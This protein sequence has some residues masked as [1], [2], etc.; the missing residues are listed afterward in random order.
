LN[1]SI[2]TSLKLNV[3]ANFAGNFASAII[4]FIFIPIYVKYIGAE[5]YGLIGFYTAL[6]GFIQIMDFGMSGT[7]NRAISK[8]RINENEK[9]LSLN[10]FR[11]FDVI[12]TIVAILIAISF[13]F[14]SEYFAENWFN[15]TSLHKREIQNSIILMGFIIAFRWPTSLYLAAFN[16]LEKQVLINYVQLLHSIFS[17]AGAII[18]LHFFESSIIAFFQW[19]LISVILLVIVL[20]LLILKEIKLFD[21]KGHFDL[22]SISKIKK[23]AVTLGFITLFSATYAHLDKI[24][25]SKFISLEDFSFYSIAA[26]IAAILY[27]FIYPVSGAIYPRIVQQ[28]HSE[29]EN[30]IINFFHKSSQIIAVLVIPLGLTL[31]FFSDDLILIWSQN[32]E[33]SRNV[34]PITSILTMGTILT[35]ITSTSQQYQLAYGYTKILFYQNLCGSLLLVPLLYFLINLFGVYG[36]AMVWVI[37]NFLQ[38]TVSQYFFFSKFLKK[39]AKQWAIHDTLKPFFV[40]VLVLGLSKFSLELFHNIVLKYVIIFISSVVA[41]LFS[42]LA[43]QH[44]R[45]LFINLLFK[46]I[47][48]KTNE[49]N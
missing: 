39:E 2:K 28:I 11:S 30:V 21:Y 5:A 7:L 9:R 8:I 1:F 27:K 35:G 34:A 41:I 17:S 40:S 46:Y 47:P 14:L 37:I 23:F 45:N 13:Y 32:G 48:L 24:I 10:L 18:I 31:C 25:I 3:I 16:G 26:S 44:T 12:N 22:I 43:M 19:Q 49:S 33:L 42:T 4:S 36:A 38:L 6:S 20:K 15:N 29:P